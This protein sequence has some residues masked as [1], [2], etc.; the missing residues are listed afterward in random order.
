VKQYLAAALILGAAAF[1]A[2]FAYLLISGRIAIAVSAPR[3]SSATT[4]AAVDL[5]VDPPTAQ[6]L[7]PISLPDLIFL[8]LPPPGERYSGWDRM[9]DAPS[10]LWV[11]PGFSSPPNRPEL[12][13]RV[14]LA[15]VRVDGAASTILLQSR[16]EL[17]WSITL[18]SE[19]NPALGPEKI[20]IE[21]GTPEDDC[22]G[23][24]TDG[25]SFTVQQAIASTRFHSEA[26]CTPN[27][28]LMDTN[29]VFKIT[30]DDREPQLL[31]YSDSKGVSGE[32]TSWV[33]IHP[34]SDQQKLCT[35]LN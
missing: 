34:L 1:F 8:A 23:S 10:I 25:C 7:E 19:N 13:E 9:L 3:S 6:A 30:A 28:V 27:V 33:E 12:T 4:G 11:T 17:A 2:V 31:V 35:R 29:E 21:P 22:F 16:E 32:E 5:P 20:E 18:S 14:G 26:V 24:L 15:R